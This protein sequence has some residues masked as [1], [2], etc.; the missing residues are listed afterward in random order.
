MDLRDNELSTKND[1]NR[2]LNTST[3][4]TGLKSKERK[5]LIDF[6]LL[7]SHFSF[8]YPEENTKCLV[9]IS[10]DNHCSPTNHHISVPYY[11]LLDF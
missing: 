3:R 2:N 6:V 8:Y 11:W 10:S 7:Y 4:Q 1:P 9:V 5:G